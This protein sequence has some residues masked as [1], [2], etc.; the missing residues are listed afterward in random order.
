MNRKFLR[1]KEKG[2]DGNPGLLFY[3]ERIQ[4]NV[5]CSIRKGLLELEFIY[6]TAVGTGADTVILDVGPFQGMGTA[7]DGIGFL[8]PVD[9]TGNRVLFDTVDVESQVIIIGFR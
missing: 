8:C 2:R 4:L 6:P 1:L 9:G 3:W 5:R 7:G